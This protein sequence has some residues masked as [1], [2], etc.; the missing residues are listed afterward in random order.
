M[1]YTPSA[2]V[3]TNSEISSYFPLSRGTRQGCPLSPLLFALAIEPHIALKS[4]SNFSGIYRGG[5]EHRVSLYAD[6]LLL[7]VSD[8]LNCMDGIIRLLIEFGSIS[9]Y[10]RNL[11]KSECFPV[12]KLAKQI[13]QLCS[14]FA[15]LVVASIIWETTSQIPSSH[16]IKKILLSC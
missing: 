6:D 8:P 12:N 1:Y 4:S 2:R 5:F 14:P 13:T 10:K 9:G 15:C 11:A 16:Y 3:K 7:F